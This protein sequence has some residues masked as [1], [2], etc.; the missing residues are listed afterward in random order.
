MGPTLDLSEKQIGKMRAAAEAFNEARRPGGSAAGAQGVQPK[1]CCVLAGQAGKSACARPPFG[2]PTRKHLSVC[3]RLTL[4]LQTWRTGDVST[5]HS[6]L[7][8]NA[9]TVSPV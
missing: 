6:L 4:P 7:A 8:P 9:H 3:P 1:C 2:Q 5:V